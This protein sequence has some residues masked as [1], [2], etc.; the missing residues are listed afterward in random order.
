MPAYMPAWTRRS[1]PQGTRLCC[2]YLSRDTVAVAVADCSAGVRADLSVTRISDLAEVKKVLHELLRALGALNLPCN[3]VLAPDLYALQLLE[4][5]DVPEAEMKEAV[6]WKLKDQVEFSIED[7]FVDAF[8]MPVGATRHQHMVYG[9]AIAGDLLKRVVECVTD[10]GLGPL[11]SI[12]IS[13]LALRNLSWRCFPMADQ[14]VGL[15]RLTGTSGLV[16]ISRGED[17]YLSRRISGV[18]DAFSESAWQEFHEHLLLQVQ[19]S[20]DYYQSAM[21]QPACDMLMVASSRDWTQKVADFLSESLS[22]PVRTVHEAMTE[23]FSLRLFDPGAKSILWT[24]LSTA[25]VDQM[26]LCLPALGGAL[27]RHIQQTVVAA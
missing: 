3:L 2:V 6:R 1:N 14:S 13:E 27:R 25:Q 15:L 22:M 12:D 19:R 4:R 20:L 10:A 7:A 17:L 23:E 9:V 18:P 11:E 8:S 16:N 24:A 26:A 5:P 21:G